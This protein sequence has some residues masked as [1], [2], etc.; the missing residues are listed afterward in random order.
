MTALEAVAAYLPQRRV[1][2]EDVAR[3]LNL[4]PAKAR[5]FRRY[6]GLAQICRDDG[7]TLLDL[8]LAAASRLGA[9]RG[10]ESRVRY[11]LHARIIPVVA[12][13]PLNPL[14]ELCGRL[15]L[16]QASAFA[17]THQA[18]ATGLLA[19]DIA[20]KLLAGEGDPD[21]LALVV[22]GEKAF[23]PAAQLLPQTSIFA[24]GA[25]ACLVSSGG[26]RDRL[27]AYASM[28]RGEFDAR[29]GEDPALAARFQREFP[30]SFAAVI[31]AALDRAGLEL[32]DISLILPHNVNVV[33]WKQLCAVTGFPLS[34]VLLENVPVIGHSFCA[35]PF[36]NYQT[37]TGRGLLRPGDHYLIAAVGAGLG[38]TFSAM[39]FRH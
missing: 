17:V 18:C 6:H 28:A 27:L 8:L 22:A 7:G 30:A 3:Q 32:A 2:V 38:A 37:A 13:F 35:D 39:V 29:P 11:V 19:V 21:G 16:R 4:H 24:E 1:P 15:G 33:A 25:S 23:T 20:G 9:L 34:R 14:H 10:R 36:I 31:R 5:V 12:P 26:Q